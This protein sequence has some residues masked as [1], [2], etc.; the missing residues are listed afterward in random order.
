VSAR[1]PSN[2]PGRRRSISPQ[3]PVWGYFA[4]QRGLPNRERP[5]PGAFLKPRP[6]GVVDYYGAERAQSWWFT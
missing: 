5:L 2:A 3:V 6:M 4:T 1:S